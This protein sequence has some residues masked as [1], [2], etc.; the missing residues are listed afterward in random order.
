MWAP[1]IAVTT[2][3]CATVLANTGRWTLL[4]AD[5]GRPEGAEGEGSQEGA[6]VS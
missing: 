4:A 3:R 2:I 5:E 1:D 6:Q